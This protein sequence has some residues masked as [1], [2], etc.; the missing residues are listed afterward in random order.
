MCKLVLYDLRYG[1][2]AK[3]YWLLLSF[4]I[5]VI[6]CISFVTVYTPMLEYESIE[7]GNHWHVTLGDFFFYVLGGNKEYT[8][9][10]LTN[11]TF[12]AIW[13]AIYTILGYA[14]FDWFSKDLRGVGRHIL[15]QS[16]RRSIWWISKCISN[17]VFTTAN[18][19]VIVLTIYLFARLCGAAD[20]L[21]VSSPTYRMLFVTE[22]D[23]IN[24]RAVLS[25][26]LLSLLACIT[27][28]LLEQAL[29]LF[30]KPVFSFMIAIGILLASTYKKSVFLIGN[31]LM[32]AR[33][34][35]LVSDG[36]SIAFG[37]V[38][39]CS[40]FVLVLFA[41]TMLFKRYDVLE[42]GREF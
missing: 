17:I 10:E 33:N 1:V 35:D 22:A 39:I 27:I 9:S 32:L 25:A 4:F 41:G 42:R 7:F 18:F 24:A 37:Y 40:L 19:C 14:A 3:W 20:S 28:S 38:L 23:E 29:C 6:G 31:Y 30:V 15:V 36:V 12:P 2:L 21:E 11:F 16:K 5:A 26:L 13:K 8:L 34:G